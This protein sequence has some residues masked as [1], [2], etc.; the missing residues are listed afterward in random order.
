M[1]LFWSF[2]RTKKNVHRIKECKIPIIVHA[3]S[4]FGMDIR[5]KINMLFYKCKKYLKI[6]TS[7]FYLNWCG[8]MG[9]YVPEW[10]DSPR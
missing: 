1:L 7:G 5:Q 6:R 10:T 2:R 8:G 3:V 9:E 4:Q